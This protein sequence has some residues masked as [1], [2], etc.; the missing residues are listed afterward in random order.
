M[1]SGMPASIESRLGP[2]LLSRCNGEALAACRSVDQLLG[3]QHLSNVV[4]ALNVV[5][6]LSR[7][8]V[9]VVAALR[10][11]P[12]I[13][14]LLEPEVP[15]LCIAACQALTSIAVHQDG[16]IAIRAGGGLQPLVQLLAE[17]VDAPT[18]ATAALAL[19]NCSA[20]DACKE[21]IAACQGITYMLSIL[22]EA[23]ASCTGGSAAALSSYMPAPGSGGR[24]D[25]AAP[26]LDASAAQAR[27]PGDFKSAVH[28]AGALMNMAAVRDVQGR[29]LDEGGMVVFTNLTKAA[30]ADDPILT[31]VNFILTWLAMSGS[32]LVAAMARD[33]PPRFP[34]KIPRSSDLGSRVGV[35]AYLDSRVSIRPVAT[36]ATPAAVPLSTAAP[37]ASEEEEDVAK[38]RA[39]LSGQ[40]PPLSAAAP[41]RPAQLQSQATRGRGKAAAK[42]TSSSGAPP[43]AKPAAAHAKSTEPTLAYTRSTTIKK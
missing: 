34:P 20:C 39:S 7:E 32:D 2:R 19:M 8:H 6:D 26:A 24:D 10:W 29:I 42:G 11:V 30:A 40:A 4:Q 12:E 38:P 16:R 3:S 17:G 35:R 22:Q 1:S 15:E 37:A 5:Q 36:P 13:V 21:A 41:A 25:A 9:A 28:A 23:T 31:R 27:T 33:P 18:A 43:P 14:K